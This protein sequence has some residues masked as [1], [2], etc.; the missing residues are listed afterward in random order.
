MKEIK[1]T[2]WKLTDKTALLYYGLFIGA[3]YFILNFTAGITMS[4]IFGTIV[5]GIFYLIAITMTIGYSYH[6]GFLYF[7]KDKDIMVFISFLMGCLVAF[8]TLFGI[9]FVTT[10]LR[11]YTDSYSFITHLGSAM[12]SI[13]IYNYAFY[14]AYL[15]GIYSI[16]L[17]L[18][19]RKGISIN[20]YTKK[21]TLKCNM[22]EPL[23]DSMVEDNGRRHR[24]R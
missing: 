7:K 22:S 14:I 17:L 10:L 13:E 2:I 24:W 19:R 12:V 8:L 3:Y 23:E 16:I 1:E 18:S 15:L 6:A 9:P 4:G 21:N 20:N 11:L 5:Y